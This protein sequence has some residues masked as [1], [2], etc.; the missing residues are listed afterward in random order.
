MIAGAATFGAITHNMHPVMDQETFTQVSGHQI[1]K[2]ETNQTAS[3]D[4]DDVQAIISLARQREERRDE[5]RKKLNNGRTP[6]QVWI[7]DVASISFFTILGT[8]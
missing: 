4:P 6:I 2:R 8:L 7:K 3:E 5:A 1:Q